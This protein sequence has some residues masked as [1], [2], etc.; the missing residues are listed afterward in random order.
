MCLPL[1]NIDMTFDNIIKSKNGKF[2]IID[3]EWLFEIPVPLNYI[4]YRSA[5]LFFPKYSEYLNGF[6]TKQEF[7]N[8]VG[9]TS[10]ELKTY[11]YMERAFRAYV[12]GTL[13]YALKGQYLKKVNEIKIKG[14]K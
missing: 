10:S 13:K 3:Y 8:A 6:L 1:A 7:F 5:I 9:I 2:F 11:G 14:H 4:I 12:H